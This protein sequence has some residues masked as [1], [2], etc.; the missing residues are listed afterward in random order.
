[1]ET[2]YTKIYLAV[3]IIFIS[4][5]AVTILAGIYIEES[6]KSQWSLMSETDHSHRKEFT[7]SVTNQIIELKDKI[8][9]LDIMTRQSPDKISIIE[10]QKKVIRAHIKALENSN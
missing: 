3:F 4:I 5:I 10:E 1:M 8:I 7:P 9:K 6:Q 2:S